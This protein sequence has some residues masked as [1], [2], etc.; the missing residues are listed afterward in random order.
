VPI[1][2]KYHFN[3]QEKQLEPIETSCWYCGKADS[4]TYETNYYQKL[5]RPHK[6]GNLIIVRW[7]T[8]KE[9]TIGV[10]RCATCN[11][12]HENASLNTALYITVAI[13]AIS[14]P[15]A[16]LLGTISIAVVVVL[17][18]IGLFSYETIKEK[19]MAKKGVA[20]PLSGALQDP[21]V[22]LFLEDGWTI[23]P[24]TA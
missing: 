18:L 6:S 9:L 23:V 16:W 3:Q 1:E 17:G 22:A 19:L 5:Y 11:D 7:T 15:F 13:V 10:P 24:P 4:A 21:T 2:D 20:S 8:Y 12:I 14:A